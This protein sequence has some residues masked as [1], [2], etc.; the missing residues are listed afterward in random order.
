MEGID[1]IVATV[2]LK[3]NDELI[4]VLQEL[5]IPYTVIGDAVKPRRITDAVR[6]AQL[7]AEK[8]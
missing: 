6:E 3:A 4:P 8:I 2:G 7:A 1:T 5:K